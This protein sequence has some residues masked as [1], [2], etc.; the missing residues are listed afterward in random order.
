MALRLGVSTAELADAR[1]IESDPELQRRVL[2][3]L[4]DRRQSWLWIVA[5]LAMR[6]SVASAAAAWWAAARCL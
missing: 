2:A 4:Q 5:V 6:A 3:A 1:D